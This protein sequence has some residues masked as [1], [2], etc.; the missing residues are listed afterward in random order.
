MRTTKLEREFQEA[1]ADAIRDAHAAGLPVFQGKDGWLV[2]IYPD[3][4]EVRLQRLTD[5]AVAML[6]KTNGRAKADPARRTER[7]G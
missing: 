6:G 7:R 5:S 4:R 1:V 2:A 3:G